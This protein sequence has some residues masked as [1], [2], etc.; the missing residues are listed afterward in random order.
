MEGLVYLSLVSQPSVRNGIC[1]LGEQ[2]DEIIA[3]CSINNGT[4][5]FDYSLLLIGD[6][7]KLLDLSLI[8]I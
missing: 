4:G 7:G 3:Y 6:D 8:H 5:D 2:G 1:S